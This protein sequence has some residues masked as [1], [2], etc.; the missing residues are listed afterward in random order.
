[1]LIASGGRPVVPAIFLKDS[2]DGIFP[3][4]SLA[5]ARSARDWLSA[6]PQVVIV[7]GGLVGVKT[8]AHLA[9]YDVS[10]TLIEKENRLLPQALTREASRYVEEHLRA[11]KI[12]LL[13]GSTVE[14]ISSD[15]GAIS[16]VR[17]NG[18]WLSCQT[19]FIAAGSLP[20]VGYL[21]GFRPASG[22]SPRGVHSPADPG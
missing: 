4:R 6:H 7:G 2:S 11:K 20:E 12:N 8:A 5:V 1:M 17:A 22:R 9:G 14:D 3:I 15:R 13:L 21:Q 10:V 18:R 19:V 16:A